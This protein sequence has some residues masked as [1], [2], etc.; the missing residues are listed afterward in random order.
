MNKVKKYKLDEYIIIN[1]YL[2]KLHFNKKFVFNFQNDGAILS[3]P[4]GKE[5]VIS[6]DTLVEKT[7]F[8]SKDSPESIAIKSI[9]SNLSDLIAM[10]A[11]PYA[12]TMSITVNNHIN[13]EW[14]KKFSN[15]L[16]S[17]QKKYNF[18]LLGGDIVKSEFLSISITVFGLI[19]KNKYVTRSGAKFNDD[20]WVTGTIGDSFI[21]YKIL[22][23]HL[24]INDLKIRNFFTKKYFFPNPPILL[25]NKLSSLMSSA[26]DVS[27]GFYGDL[28]KIT[29][30]NNKGAEIYIKSFP[31]SQRA[32]N[33]IKSKKISIS[34]L[35]TGG[36]DYQLIFTSNRKNRENI[37]KL[38]KISRI[39]ITNIGKINK[40]NKLNLFNHNFSI[41]KKNYIHEI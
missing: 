40:S 19:N 6:Q 4:K 20:I 31:F 29:L 21:G 13:N 23:N 27:D 32:L 11:F 24:K 38:S 28:E 14:L 15:S 33:L 34:D 41:N 7:H 18:F 35:L 17:E 26:I 1:K 39:K 12:Y 22:K 2:K 8:F 37:L 5:L 25:V 16:Y 10:G 36:D 3:I 9:R 30:N